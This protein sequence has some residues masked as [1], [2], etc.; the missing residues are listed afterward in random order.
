MK[1]LTIHHIAA[2]ADHSA[3]V[4][5]SYQQNMGAQPQVRETDFAFDLIDDERRLVQWYM[6]EYLTFLWAD[7]RRTKPRR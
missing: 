3:R 1:Q 4:R 6:E 7:H 2:G 5:V